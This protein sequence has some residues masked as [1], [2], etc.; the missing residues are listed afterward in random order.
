MGTFFNA[1]VAFVS[2]VLVPLLSSLGIDE[3]RAVY[4]YARTYIQMQYGQVY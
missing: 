1:R 3:K 4:L 2:G